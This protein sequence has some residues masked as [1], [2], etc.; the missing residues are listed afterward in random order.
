VQTSTNLTGTNWISIY[1][2]VSPFNFNAT[3]L[4]DP[5]RFYRAVSGE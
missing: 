2:N 4:L 5:Q 3:N 1:T